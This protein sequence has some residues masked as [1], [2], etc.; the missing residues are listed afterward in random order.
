VSGLRTSSRFYSLIIWILPRFAKRAHG[1]ILRR[2][3][4]WL[5]GLWSAEG[6]PVKTKLHG[7]EVLLNR[8][9]LY[10]F[11]LY[12][13]PLF[14]APLVQL[15]HQLSFEN[16]SPLTF[17]DVGAAT[18]DT[19]LLLKQ[20]CPGCVKRFICVEG[21]GEF[22]VLLS[23]NMSQFPEVTVEKALLS[24][25]QMRIK[26]LVKH[27]KG[28]AASIGED[29][30]DAVCLDSIERIQRA[31]VD[32]LKIDVDGFDGEVLAGSINTLNRCRSAVIFEWHPKLATMTKNEPLRAFKVLASCGYTR[33]VWFNNTGTFSHFSDCCSLDVLRKEAEY[34]LAINSRA[35]DH[36]DVVALHQKT[37]LDEIQLAISDFARTR[38]ID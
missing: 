5:H 38:L 30:V 4:W 7:F 15:V 26:S 28:T 22:Q 3:Y 2:I 33:Y 13:T 11:I 12:G 31:H 19:V 27:H 14:N 29:M 16:R 35:G 23:E 24:S 9:N 8:G 32:I 20:H 6:P 25:R 34:L 17:V 36:F 21:D 37:E 18:G 10:P 1:P